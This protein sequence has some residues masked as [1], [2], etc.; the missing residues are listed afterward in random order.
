M[1]RPTYQCLCPM[2]LAGGVIQSCAVCEGG[3]CMWY[4]EGKEICA[5]A[6]TILAKNALAE[7]EGDG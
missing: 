5:C 7:R 1:K 3:R 4:V 6:I 2:K